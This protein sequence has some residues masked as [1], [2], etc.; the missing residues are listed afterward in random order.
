M[1]VRLVKLRSQGQRLP[2]WGYLNV[3][4]LVGSLNFYQ[5]G[6]KGM[7]TIDVLELWK[8][9][10]QLASG[11]LATLYEPRLVALGNGLMLFRG[12][13]V[14]GNASVTQEW[15]VEVHQ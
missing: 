2:P 14:V 13:D 10:E 3:P 4:P 7:G 11:R 9:N 8:P 12:V 6:T 5:L 15:R 1:K